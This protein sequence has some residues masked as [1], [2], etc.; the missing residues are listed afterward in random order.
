MKADPKENIKTNP[1][2]N[3]TEI[4]LINFLEG[5]NNSARRS[6]G[7]QLKN[8]QKNYFCSSD[9]FRV[10]EVFILPI[11]CSFYDSKPA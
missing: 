11:S 8:G 4:R 2:K 6:Q 7:V 3:L 5:V 10:A 9:S 1:F